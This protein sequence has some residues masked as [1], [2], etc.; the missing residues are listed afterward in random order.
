[1][2]DLLYKIQVSKNKPEF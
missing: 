1:M 2:E